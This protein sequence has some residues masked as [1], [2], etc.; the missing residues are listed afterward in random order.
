MR[1][2][3]RSDAQHR[4]H[5]ER[6]AGFRH[7]RRVGELPYR[8]QQLPSTRGL[9]SR[10]QRRQQ[11]CDGDAVGCTVSSPSP[12]PPPPFVHFPIALRRDH[13]PERGHPG[14]CGDRT[15]HAHNRRA[16]RRDRRRP[17]ERLPPHRDGTC[18][19]H[20]A[21]GVHERELPRRDGSR[22]PTGSAIVVGT[23]G[24]DFSTHK[25]A[26]VTTHGVPLQQRKH[27]DPPVRNRQAEGSPRRPRDSTAP[28]PAATAPAPARRSSRWGRSSSSRPVRLRARSSG[29]GGRTFPDVRSPPRCGSPVAPTSRATG[30]LPQVVTRPSAAREGLSPLPP[31]Q[32]AARSPAGARVP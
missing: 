11:L 2:G 23:I 29:D 12:P 31:D 17:D 16:V 26:I 7:V 6:G 15:R 8:E 20:R 30:L 24:G 10:G 14:Q 18:E 19:R 5:R 1:R 3:W 32:R 9:Q 25:Y 21:G 4:G 13:Q 27:L 28:S 22:R